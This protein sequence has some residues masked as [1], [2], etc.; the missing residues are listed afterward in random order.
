MQMQKIQILGPF[1]DNFKKTIGNESN[2]NSFDP[3]R[4]N[5]MKETCP[6]LR[7]LATEDQN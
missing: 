5:W 6:A 7:M 1:K 3:S 4:S 2:S